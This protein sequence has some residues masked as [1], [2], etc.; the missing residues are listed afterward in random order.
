M[1]R[2]S[3]QQGQPGMSRDQQQQGQPGMQRDQQPGQY[4]Q[5]GSQPQAQDPQRERRS[6]G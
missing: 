1:S 2:E 4:N 6:Q 5:R 3:Q